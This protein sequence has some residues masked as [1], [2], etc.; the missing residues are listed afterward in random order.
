MK[1]RRTPKLTKLCR[2]CNKRIFR[3]ESNA[4]DSVAARLSRGEV[5]RCY[6]CPH[7]QGFHITKQTKRGTR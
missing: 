4:L 7:M 5:R 1:K 2:P 6:P 3:S